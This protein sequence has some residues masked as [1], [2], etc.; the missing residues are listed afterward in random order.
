M[1]RK[2]LQ[3]GMQRRETRKREQKIYYFERKELLV[4]DQRLSIALLQD[5]RKNSPASD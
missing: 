2:I 3:K 4:F 5:I 1:Q